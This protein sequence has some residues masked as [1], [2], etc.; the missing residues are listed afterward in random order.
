MADKK[1]DLI[2][3][4]GIVSLLGG[5]LALF[6]GH[7]GL[8]DKA[9]EARGAIAQRVAAIRQDAAD[10]IREIG[11]QPDTPAE[12][13]EEAPTRSY[14]TPGPPPSLDLPPGAVPAREVGTSP[15]IT[16]DDYPEEALYNEVQGTVTIVWTITSLG[17][18]EHCHVVES[19]GHA[20]LD[21][22]AC[23]AIIR[24]ARYEPARDREGRAIASIERRRVVWQ[25][26]E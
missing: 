1:T 25:L 22:A 14:I 4:V 21:E 2:L 3:G 10:V 17:F 19:S 5:G 13:P 16:S 8:A 26:P 20:Q 24:R 18:V 7:L 9:A 12:A 6:V 11:T 15:L 23:R